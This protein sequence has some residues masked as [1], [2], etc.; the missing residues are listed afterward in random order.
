MG[1]CQKESKDQEIGDGRK[2][3]E[4]PKE[5]KEGLTLKR[6]QQSSLQK[7]HIFLL[8]SRN[9]KKAMTSL[10]LYILDDLIFGVFVQTSERLI[11][12]D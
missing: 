11:H 6:T 12:K 10:F 2:G 8:M 3:T 7:V 5:G 9:Q 4:N 1:D